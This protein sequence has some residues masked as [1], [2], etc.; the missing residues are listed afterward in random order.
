M[1]DDILRLYCGNYKPPP[2]MT[3]DERIIE[4]IRFLGRS[5]AERSYTEQ[6]RQSISEEPRDD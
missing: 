2:P 4:I 1:P 6:Q 5:A 3:Y